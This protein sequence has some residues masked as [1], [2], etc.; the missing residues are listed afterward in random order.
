MLGIL[1][2]TEGPLVLGGDLN[3]TDGGAEIR[4]L[5]AAMSDSFEA[6]PEGRQHCEDPSG[7][8]T[9]SSSGAPLSCEAT[10]HLAGRWREATSP[11]TNDRAAR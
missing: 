7:R 5:A 6:A 10:G 2:R 8:S 3:A 1:E 11:K 9:T 4:Q